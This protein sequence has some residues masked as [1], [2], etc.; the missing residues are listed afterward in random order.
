MDEEGNI[1]AEEDHHL[2]PI[3]LSHLTL[4]MQQEVMK[5]TSHLAEGTYVLSVLGVEHKSSKK[6]GRTSLSSH[7]MVPM[8]KLIR[9]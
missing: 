8:A 2:L 6:E 1:N 3:H 5:S 7:M 9:Y 4:Q